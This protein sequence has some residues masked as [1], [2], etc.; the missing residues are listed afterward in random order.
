[1]VGSSVPLDSRLSVPGLREADLPHRAGASEW[2]ADARHGQ[3]GSVEGVVL[4][5]EP[6]AGRR[7]KVGV[8]L[9]R[10]RSAGLPLASGGRAVDADQP[11]RRLGLCL[12]G[13]VYPLGLPL[14]IDVKRAGDD[15]RVPGPF[16]VQTDEVL[17][18][19]GKE[20]P[21][22]GSGEGQH[23][24]VGDGVPGFAGLPHGQH[25]VSQLPERLDEG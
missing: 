14:E 11:A 7:E 22:V 23:L 6:R 24:F 9:S 8:A 20:E 10:C 3:V 5:A 19:Q 1:M 2:A 21:V 4:V 18:V 17:A 12:E 15:A 16:L 25:V 13:L